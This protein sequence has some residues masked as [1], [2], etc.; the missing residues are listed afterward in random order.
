MD[1]KVLKPWSKVNAHERS[2][3][4][5]NWSQKIQENKEEIAEVMTL[6]N[7]KPLK[8]HSVKWIMQRVILIGMRK[9]QNESM[10]AQFPQLRFEKNCC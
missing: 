6:E 4:L 5:K 9:K 1:M 10:D 3:L 2:R 8:N 7:G